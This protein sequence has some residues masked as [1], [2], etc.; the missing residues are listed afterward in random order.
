MMFLIR[1]WKS[2]TKKDSVE[3]AKYE[4][5][6]FSTFTPV[7]GRFFHRSGFFRIGSGLREKK[8]DPDPSAV[9]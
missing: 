6:F 2:L 5:Q 4:I 1:C 8:S 3:S 7:L 9:R